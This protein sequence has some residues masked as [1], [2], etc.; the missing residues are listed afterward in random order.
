[1]YDWI[2][3]VYVLF[4]ADCVFMTFVPCFCEVVLGLK[5]VVSLSSHRGLQ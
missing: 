5:E 3:E 4:I 1:M 2:I